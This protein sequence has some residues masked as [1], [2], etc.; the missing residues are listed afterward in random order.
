[1]H[2]QFLIIW[3]G[4]GGDTLSF[5]ILYLSAYP[6][7]VNQHFYKVKT[8]GKNFTSRY[9]DNIIVFVPLVHIQENVS[10]EDIGH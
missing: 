4:G 2:V 7:V 6:I 8:L 9:L 3:G 10:P 5:V 1:M